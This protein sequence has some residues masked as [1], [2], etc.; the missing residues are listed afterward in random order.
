MRA[1]RL[2]LVAVLVVGWT[3]AASAE[4]AWVLWKRDYTMQKWTTGLKKRSETVWIIMQA[5]DTRNECSAK[6]EEVWKDEITGWERAAATLKVEIRPFD[7]ITIYHGQI[8]DMTSGTTVDTFYCLP[9]TIDP[10]EKKE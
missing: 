5:T 10:R 4:C 9:D 6:K 8:G 3:S 7:S 2:V 1:A